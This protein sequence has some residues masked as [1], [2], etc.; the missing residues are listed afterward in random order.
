[1][2][3]E[4]LTLRPSRIADASV[5][6]DRIANENSG[7][8]RDSAILLSNRSPAPYRDSMA[9]PEDRERVELSRAPRVQPLALGCWVVGASSAMF[10]LLRNSGISD[11]ALSAYAAW[12]GATVTLAAVVIAYVE[13]RSKR[14]N[15]LMSME[16]DAARRWF[17]GW[18][19]APS[20]FAVMLPMVD[21]LVAES[22][23]PRG[24]VRMHC[25]KCI[26]TKLA[27]DGAPITREAFLDAM[28]DLGQ[29]L[30]H[31]TIDAAFVHELLAPAR[32]N[33][34]ATFAVLS[35][36]DFYST[37]TDEDLARAEAVAL[38]RLFRVWLESGQWTARRG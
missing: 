5:S 8:G 28:N 13:Y 37:G 15:A 20:A 4:S 24:V 7:V 38:G 3:A 26:H 10:L 35:R 6:G 22:N 31:R 19:N 33:I 16:L 21:R 11:G 9:L 27:G 17:E 1:V 29:Q 30:T 18:R 23:L 34:S 25:D 2:F 14:R 32:D 12:L 36:E